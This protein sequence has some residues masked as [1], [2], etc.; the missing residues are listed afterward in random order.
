MMSDAP[1]R[2]SQLVAMKRQS[3]GLSANALSLACG[4]S[5]S[6]VG[7]FETGQIAEPSLSAFARMARVLRMT[8]AEVY[9]AVMV[10]S[11]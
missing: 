1:P 2:A 10:E 8:P 3:A 4:L 6:Y 5:K 11:S 9:V 7:K